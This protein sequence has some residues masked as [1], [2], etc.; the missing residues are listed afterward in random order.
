MVSL[1]A[2]YNNDFLGDTGAIA[3]KR[4]STLRACCVLAIATPSRAAATPTLLALRT[5]C[6]KSLAQMDNFCADEAGAEAA[7]MN[8]N[9]HCPPSTPDATSSSGAM[10]GSAA[11]V[12][13]V[14]KLSDAWKFWE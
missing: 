4:T 12:G 13:L 14:I 9:T 3:F 7:P 11:D 10:T 1:S 8:S 5:D 2:C 6:F